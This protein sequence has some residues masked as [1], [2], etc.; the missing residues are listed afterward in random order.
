MPKLGDIYGRKPVFS[1]SAVLNAT[2]YTVLMVTESLTVLTVVSFMFG[3]ISS[4]RVNIGYVYLIEFMPKSWQST[5]GSVWSVIEGSIYV[6]ATLSFWLLTRNWFFFVSIG[7]F[8]ALASACT[9][10]LL[11]ESPRYLI[12]T[13]QIEEAELCLL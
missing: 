1:V 6:M 10:W 4:L 9:V 8:L 11:P 2:L 3:M 5:M 7:Y 12:E 13:Q